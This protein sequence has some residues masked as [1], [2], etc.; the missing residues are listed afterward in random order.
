[1]ALEYSCFISYR[2]NEHENKF[3]TNFKQILLAELCKLTNK[4]KGFFDEESIRFAE[5]FDDK[6]Y[7]GIERSCFFTLIWHH[8]YLNIENSWCAKEL[9]HALKVEEKI[10]ELM[11]SP[12]KENFFFILPFVYRGTRDELPVCISEDNAIDLQPYEYHISN[13][14]PSKALTKRMQDIYRDVNSYFLVLDKYSGQIDFTTF[15]DNIEKPDDQTL[16]NWI[17]VQKRQFSQVESDSFPVLK[18]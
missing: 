1:M 9:Y 17:R 5:K 10:K 14:K 3:I 18:N 4:P 15:F 7:F 12:D 11:P 6:I 8:Q 2:R 16:K 13:K